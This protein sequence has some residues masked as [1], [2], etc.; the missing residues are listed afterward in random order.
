MRH[1]RGHSSLSSLSSSSSREETARGRLDAIRELLAQ[2]Y[3]VNEDWDDVAFEEE[4]NPGGCVIVM[5]S[6]DGVSTR[7]SPLFSSVISNDIATA[8][9]LLQHGANAEA[10]CH[11]GTTVLHEA[12]ERRLVEMLKLLC[13]YNA[14]LE[15]R[16]AGGGLKGFTPLHTAVRATNLEMVHELLSQGSDAQAVTDDGWRAL[17]IAIL[18]HQASIVELLMGHTSST[19]AGRQCQAEGPDE[20]KD[21]EIQALAQY[22]LDYVI[23]FSCSESQQVDIYRACLSKVYEGLRSQNLTKPERARKM[24]QG[25]DKEL[26]QLT[27]VQPKLAW[28][29]SLCPQCTAFQDQD[30]LDFFQ[31]FRHSKNLDSLRQSADNGC[32]L[33]QILCEAYQDQN[34]DSNFRDIAGK[35]GRDHEV[36]LQAHH[37]RSYAT[38]GGCAYMFLGCD[39]KVVSIYLL[40]MAGK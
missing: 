17:D 29:R 18:T 22:L 6:M 30:V 40:D 27:G 4:H 39:G 3:D 13:K 35:L 2:G 10:K 11:A 33:C 23:E 37:S 1:Y 16:T 38:G 7:V 31:E 36:R 8:E 19:M 26:M 12:V 24:V 34:H 20:T 14:D 25:I 9:L 15:A 21:L 28:P 5:H 32:D